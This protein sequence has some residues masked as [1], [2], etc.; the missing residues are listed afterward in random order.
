MVNFFTFT[1]KRW[2]LTEWNLSQMLGSTRNYSLIL[3]LQF[4]FNF[5]VLWFTIFSVLWIW[6]TV[7]AGHTRQIILKKQKEHYVL[8][9][10]CLCPLFWTNKIPLQD[11]ELCLSVKILDFFLGAMRKPEKISTP[12]WVPFFNSKFW[13]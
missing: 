13:G 1:I 5:L 4:F 6:S 8:K 9:K 7:P 12:L 3:V 10:K 11:L 2:K